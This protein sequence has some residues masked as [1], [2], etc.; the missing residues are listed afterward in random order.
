MSFVQIAHRKISA[1]SFNNLIL[2]ALIRFYGLNAGA[3]VY[4]WIFF[5]LGWY[6][7]LVWNEYCSSSY[8]CAL[9]N[10]PT[11]FK[12]IFSV[13]HN[14]I[15]LFEYIYMHLFVYNMYIVCTYIFLAISWDI[16]THI[17]HST[18][19]TY[20]RSRKNRVLCIVWVSSV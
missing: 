3:S 14:V 4:F 13:P 10:I 11:E 16:Y 2:N 7:N 9:R 1:A 20:Y 8:A 6:T 19:R 15:M 17:V 12:C 18:V 5:F